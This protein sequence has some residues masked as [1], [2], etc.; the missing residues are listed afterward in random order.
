MVPVY[1]NFEAVRNQRKITVIRHIEGD[2]WVIRM[3]CSNSFYA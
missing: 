2:I 3:H 1:L